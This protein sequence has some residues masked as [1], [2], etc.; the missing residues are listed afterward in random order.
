MQILC[1]FS[2]TLNGKPDGGVDML[3]EGIDMVSLLSTQATLGQGLGDE[4]TDAIYKIALD[5]GVIEGTLQ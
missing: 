2:R 1:Y 5:R 4:I 3:V